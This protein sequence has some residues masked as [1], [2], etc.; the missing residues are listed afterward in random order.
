MSIR[1]ISTQRL[2]GNSTV[3]VGHKGEIFYDPDNISILRFSDGVT[4]GGIDLSTGGLPSGGTTGQVLAKINGTDYNT[5]WVTDA[6]DRLVN[7]NSS[8]I[9]G[10]D[11]ILTLSNS[12]TIDA[13]AGYPYVTIGGANTY[14]T[15]DDGGAPPGITITTNDGDL[16]PKN[17]RFDTDGV[18]TFPDSSQQETAYR[19]SY[20]NTAPELTSGAMWFNSEEG[21]LYINYDDTWVEANP[22]QIDPTAIRFNDQNQIELPEGGDIVDSLG[23]SVLNGG[24]NANTGNV[25]FNDQIVIGTGDDSGGGGLYLAPGTVSVGNL[26]YLRVRGGDDPTHIHLDTGDGNYYDQYFGDDNIY[27]KLESNSFGF[28]NVVIGTNNNSHNWS[29]GSNGNLLLPTYQFTPASISTSQQIGEFP[30]EIT[31]RGKLILTPPDVESSSQSLVVYATIPDPESTHLHIASGDLDVTDLFLGT[32]DKFVKVG[33]DG[34]VC[35]GTNSANSIWQFDSNGATIFPNGAKLD[36]GTAYKFATDNTVTQYVD[37]RDTS[38]RGFYTDSNGYTLRSSET[39]SW[40]FGTTGVATFPYSNYI[41]TTDTNLKIGSHGDVTIRANAQFSPNTVSWIFGADSTIQFPNDIIQAPA[42]NSIT[43]QSDQ[44]S[45]LMWQNA[46]V[47]VAPN[48]A[49]YSNFYVGQN[50]ATLDIGYLDGSSNPQ[51]KEWIWSVDGSLT[52]PGEIKSTAGTGNVVINANNGTLRTWVF[53]SDGSLTFPDGTTNSGGAV[54]APADYDMQS[55]GNILIQTSANYNAKTWTFGPNGNL[56]LPAN[57][58]VSYSPNV[59]GDW[60]S[61]A[62]TSIQEALDRLATLVKALNSGTGA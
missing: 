15:I 1:R 29:F 8:V 13:S 4:T 51:F 7:G 36:N 28:G 6:K 45:Q 9:L 37:L 33:A 12:I 11:G 22:T 56:T 55:I 23:N 35:I 42:G 16:G 41:E 10:S 3:Y 43:M 18:L 39:N 19:Y 25:T 14:I 57:G 46:N 27:L 53:G 40:S 54:V 47:T 62:P 31:E 32:D 58:T 17:W 20:S 38:G 52:L 60:A 44:Y 21:R 26:Q 30:G 24:G 2:G 48:M 59:S 61:P 50:N 49:T 5:A 34:I